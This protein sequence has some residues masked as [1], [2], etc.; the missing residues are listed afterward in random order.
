[1]I[2]LTPTMVKYSSSLYLGSKESEIEI[3]LVRRISLS[4]STK[5][6]MQTT[7]F[8]SNDQLCC[9]RKSLNIKQAEVFTKRTNENSCN[10]HQK[11]MTLFLAKKIF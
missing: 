11:V 4:Q 9:A 6:L 10:S 5:Q 2:C 8:S 1:M 3:W 7:C